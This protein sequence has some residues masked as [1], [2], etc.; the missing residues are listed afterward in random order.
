M[1]QLKERRSSNFQDKKTFSGVSI[2]VENDTD[3]HVF[4]LN[5]KIS[6]LSQPLWGIH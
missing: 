3:S 5:T 1:V 4:C 6:E 2:F